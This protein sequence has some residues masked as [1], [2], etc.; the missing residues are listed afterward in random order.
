MP[1]VIVVPETEEFKLHV[2]HENVVWITTNLGIPQLDEHDARYLAPFWLSE[3]RGVSRLYH[4][5]RNKIKTDDQSTDIPL[6]N[7]FVLETPWTDM[8]QVRRFEYHDLASFGLRELEEHQGIL[9][10]ASA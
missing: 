3:P 9:V 2:S 7:S 8:G 1:K 5:Q 10:K 6:G 4:I